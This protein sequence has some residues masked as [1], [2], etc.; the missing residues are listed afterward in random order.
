MKSG[1]NK[2]VDHLLRKNGMRNGIG[3]VSFHSPRL[4]DYLLEQGYALGNS[5]PNYRVDWFY[6][7][8]KDWKLIPDA[9]KMLM[10][11][12]MIVVSL[13]EGKLNELRKV[14]K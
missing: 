5:F 2:K 7:S 13:G 11:G 14:V 6:L 8:K 4:R 12:G 1:F 3:W 10:D 9:L